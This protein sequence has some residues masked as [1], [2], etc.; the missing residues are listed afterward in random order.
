M[1]Y[2]WVCNYSNIIGAI[3]EADTQP[4][5]PEHLSPPPNVSGARI[6]RSLILCVIFGRSLCVLMFFFLPLCCL[7]FFDLRILITPLVSSNSS[8]ILKAIVQRIFIDIY[9]N[10][11]I[12]KMNAV[13]NQLMQNTITKCSIQYINVA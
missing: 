12:H 4:T 7:L 8:Y 6:T 2:H 3:S 13:H 9:F 11:S 1:T 10:C 5:H